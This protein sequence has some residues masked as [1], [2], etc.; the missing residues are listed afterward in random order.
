MYK[1][2]LE[3]CINHAF[4]RSAWKR[5]QGHTR[6]MQHRKWSEAAAQ[7]RSEKES[8]QPFLAGDTISNKNNEQFLFTTK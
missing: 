6:I 8:F 1:L 5:V 7:Q 2:M 4:A 3:F